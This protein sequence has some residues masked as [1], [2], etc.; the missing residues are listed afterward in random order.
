MRHKGRNNEWQLER[1]FGLLRSARNQL[2]LAVLLALFTSSAAAQPRD[3]ALRVVERWATAFDNSDVEAITNLYAPEATFLGTSSTGVLANRDAIRG[4]F[5]RALLVDRPRTATL[6]DVAVTVLG[7]SAVIV[8]GTDVVTR[9]RDG[10][11]IR[12]AGRVTFVVVERAGEWRIAHFHRSAMPTVQPS[13]P[14]R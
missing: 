12:A 10:A 3:E 2:V 8:T 14:G 13:S 11:T 4:Y 6:D 9:V 1:G 5:E 7:P